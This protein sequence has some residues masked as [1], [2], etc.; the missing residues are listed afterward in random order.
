MMVRIG[1]LGA[2][3]VAPLAIAAPARTVSGVRVEAVAAR[4]PR[5]GR[6]FA[7][8]HDIAQVYDSYD[9]LLNA[10]GI[11]AVYV[12]LPAALNGHWT[13]RALQAGKHVLVEKPMAANAAEAAQVAAAA[14][15]AKRVVFQG[16][17][18]AYHPFL[19][20]V[21]ELL[22]G[23]EIGKV[24]RV[25]GWFEVARPPEWNIRWRYELGGG[26]LMDHGSYPVHLAR[27]LIGR[28]PVVTSATAVRAA[29]PRN[30]AVMDLTLDF[31]EGVT[32]TVHSSMISDRLSIGAVV[33]GVA[34]R[35]AVTNF[36]HPTMGNEI[37][38]IR[39]GGERCYGFDTQR[40]TFAYQLESFRDAV[41]L[42]TRFPT[43]VQDGVRNLAVID[44]GYQAAG[45]PLRQPF[46]GSP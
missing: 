15:A 1:I 19:A 11:D 25:D 29:E 7:A 21:R 44:A 30:D 40:R 35:I 12:G 43:D 13:V 10:P 42:G 45:L 46:V 38:I 33:H 18:Y 36:I 39:P 22:A 5:R 14:R 4:A 17:H 27:T 16:Y 23:D 9:E 6:D 20:H 32:G 26:T 3:R 28:E 31:G 41:L 34:G 37:R 24:V 8:E 2:S